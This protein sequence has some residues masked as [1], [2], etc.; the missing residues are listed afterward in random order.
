MAKT[1]RAIDFISPKT[2]EFMICRTMTRSKM[3]GVTRFDLFS[4]YFRRFWAERDRFGS[5]TA[6]SKFQF[7][8]DFL[9]VG[10][11]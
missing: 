11:L 9:G 5:L 4:V 3:P 1:T 10:S 2:V 7:F 6:R 8:C